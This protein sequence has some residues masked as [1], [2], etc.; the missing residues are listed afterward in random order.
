MRSPYVILCS[1]MIL[2][3]MLLR[4]ETDFWF[5]PG[6]LAGEVSYSISGAFWV[7]SEGSRIVVDP[8]SE[9]TFPLDGPTLRGG[10][11]TRFANYWEAALSGS[12]MLSDPNAPCTDSDWD[13]YG[14]LVIYSDS[15][16][17]LDA[18]ELDTAVRRWFVGQGLDFAIGAGLLY[19]SQSWELANV[20]QWYPPY[21]EQ[22]HDYVAGLIGSYDVQTWMPYLEIATRGDVREWSFWGRAMLSPYTQ[23]DD[24]DDHKLRYILANTSATGLGGA[25]DG[26][27]RRDLAHDWFAELR[28]RLLG[29]FASGFEQNFT[30]DGP[31]KG[32]RWEMEHKVSSTQF[33]LTLA[34]GLAL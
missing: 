29:Y 23:I 7:A 1:L 15:D 20:D 6:Y 32:E 22:K 34:I 5:G 16:A 28:G 18:Y 10:C 3:P 8:I 25:L 31:D 9:L 13:A 17:C 30:Y 19:Q 11:T 33:M 24:V 4:A 26:T 21:P 27:I 2:T 14:T 12:I